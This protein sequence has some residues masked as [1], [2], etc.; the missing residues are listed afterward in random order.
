LL[1]H[2][3]N[4][5]TTKFVCF[6]TLWN[7]CMA[8]DLLSFQHSGIPLHLFRTVLTCLGHRKPLFY[9]RNFILKLFLQRFLASLYN[10]TALHG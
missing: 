6:V 4:H 3:E 8:T 5:P 1:E 10:V 9:S 2:F 7:E